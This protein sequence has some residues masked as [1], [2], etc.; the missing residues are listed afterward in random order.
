MFG[1]GEDRGSPLP[2]PSN[3]ADGGMNLASAIACGSP[4][5]TAIC[6]KSSLSFIFQLFLIPP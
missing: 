6:T 5:E 2:R 1:A 3:P 4:P